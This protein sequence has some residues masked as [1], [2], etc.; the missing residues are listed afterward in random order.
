MA[1]KAGEYE[2]EL[3][4]ESIKDLCRQLPG[5]IVTTTDV[6]EAFGI[7]QQAVWYRLTKLEERGEMKRKKVGAKANIWWVVED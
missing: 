4:Y 6:R 2:G 7:S 3:S 1:V 5:G